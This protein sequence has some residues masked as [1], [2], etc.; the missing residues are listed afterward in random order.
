MHEKALLVGQPVASVIRFF[1]L[2]VCNEILKMEVLDKG[3]NF[4][5][6]LTEH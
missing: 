6:T 5:K 1:C 3:R 4:A 2:I